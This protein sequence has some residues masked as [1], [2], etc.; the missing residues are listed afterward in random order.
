MASRESPTSVS[1]RS[2][3][4]F[5]NILP[6]EDKILRFYFARGFFYLTQN[7]CPFFSIWEVG[8]IFLFWGG[9]VYDVRITLG[10]W[11]YFY[12]FFKYFMSITRVNQKHRKKNSRVCFAFSF[13]GL[14]STSTKILFLNTSKTKQFRKAVT[15]NVKFSII[16]VHLG[17]RINLPSRLMI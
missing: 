13:W 6:S 10:K 12:T 3:Q 14:N 15:L 5:K 9:G 8:V 16:E 7:K 11:R 17:R 4:V 2:A 1:A